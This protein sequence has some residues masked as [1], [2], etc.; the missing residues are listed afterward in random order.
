MPRSSRAV[1]GRAITSELR[2]EMDVLVVISNC[3]QE[4]NP[5]AGG[6]PTPVRAVVWQG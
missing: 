6:G 2:A 1:R 4:L 3:P 5:A